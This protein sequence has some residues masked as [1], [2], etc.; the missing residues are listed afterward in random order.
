MDMLH[1]QM[2]LRID[3]IIGDILKYGLIIIG[4]MIGTFI[5]FKIYAFFF[6]LSVELKMEKHGVR[7]VEIID[8]N[9]ETKDDTFERAGFGYMVAGERGWLLGAMTGQQWEELKSVTFMIYYKNRTT[10]K[11]TCPPKKDLFK[12]LIKLAGG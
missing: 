12:K 5:I 7:K 8:V 9:Y 10:Q 2:Y 4:V 6:Y 1:F 11:V 3:K